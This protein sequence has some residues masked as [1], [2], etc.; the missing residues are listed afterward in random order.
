M[1]MNAAD[2]TSLAPE[3]PLRPALRKPHKFPRLHVSFQNVLS[4]AD[5][6]WKIHPR[7]FKSGLTSPAGACFQM[8]GLAHGPL[9]RAGQR[10][11]G[12]SGPGTTALRGS[13][14]CTLAGDKRVQEPRW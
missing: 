1:P 14:D 9:Q 2:R 7:R 8:S 5:V 3:G 10:G 4:A 11:E 12:R 6:L 13:A